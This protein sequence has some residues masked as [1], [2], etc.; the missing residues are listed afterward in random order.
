MLDTSYRYKIITNDLFF[1]IKS[2]ASIKTLYTQQLS[3]SYFCFNWRWDSSSM[4]FPFSATFNKFQNRSNVL[5]AFTDKIF[6]EYEYL[7]SIASN[8]LATFHQTLANTN[9]QIFSRAIINRI[10]RLCTTSSMYFQS[11]PCSWTKQ[12]KSISVAHL[13]LYVP[14]HILISLPRLL[15][16]LLLNIFVFLMIE[17]DPSRTRHKLITVIEILTLTEYECSN[18]SS[19]P[20]QHVKQRR[21]LIRN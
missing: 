11:C 7:P 20:Q 15:D 6:G 12:M 21:L 4:T 16:T 3:P 13:D 17:K 5:H 9:T 2:D 10:L 8:L 14:L 1:R 18:Q 19:F